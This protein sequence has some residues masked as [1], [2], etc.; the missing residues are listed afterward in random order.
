MHGDQVKVGDRIM[1]P[2]YPMFAVTVNDLVDCEP[3]CL[4]G[5]AAVN[6]PETG[7]PDEVCLGTMELVP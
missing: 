1:A 7:D 3:N 6:D 2:G 5:A 4:Y